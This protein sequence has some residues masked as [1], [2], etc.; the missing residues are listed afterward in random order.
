MAIEIRRERSGDEAA[1]YLVTEAAFQGRPYAGGDEQDLV[2]RLRKLG[3]ISLSLVAV[4][5]EDLV[6]QVTF[7]PVTLSD[8]SRPWFGLGPISVTPDR[9]DEGIG[10]QLIWAGLDEIDCRGALGCV[11]TGNPIYYQRFGFQPSPRNVPE[12][13]SAEFFQIKL[14]KA[15]RA[16]GTF[17]FHPAFYQGGRPL[18]NK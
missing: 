6:G 13:E 7:S 10:G 14:M 15:V 1:I 9:Q 12:E 17:A 3:Q 2:N 5:C 18:D 8:G 11:L 16:E 4:D